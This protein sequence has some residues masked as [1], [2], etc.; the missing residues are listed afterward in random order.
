MGWYKN[1]IDRLQ[2]STYSEKIKKVEKSL[3]KKKN[4]IM[5]SGEK[6]D[7]KIECDNLTNVDLETLAY[8]IS[9]KFSFNGVYGVPRGGVRLADALK[10]YIDRDAI[11]YLIVDDVLTTGNSM[12]EAAKKFR[13]R[14]SLVGVVIFSRSKYTIPQWIHPIFNMYE[15]WSK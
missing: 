12:I 5:H 11:D 6:S 9:K 4:F 2:N 13:D 10:K 3:F 15:W 7:F 8:L 14:R 1:K